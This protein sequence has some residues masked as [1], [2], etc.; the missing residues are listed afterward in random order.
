MGIILLI[1]GVMIILIG[2]LIAL[3]MN[4]GKGRIEGGGLILIGP[5]PI[6]LGT[7][8][9]IITIMMII[10]FFLLILMFILPIWRFM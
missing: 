3:L 4:R 10:V 8:R 7:N 1:I 2:T 6:F 5:I 9:K